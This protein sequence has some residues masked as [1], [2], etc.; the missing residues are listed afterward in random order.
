MRIG[1]IGAGKVGFSL[2]R[3]LAEG[4][5]TVTGYYSRNSRSAREA[6]EFTGEH[7]CRPLFQV[8][9]EKGD[10]QEIYRAKSVIL[11][12]GAK[13]RP[14]GLEDEHRRFVCRQLR[15]AHHHSCRLRRGRMVLLAR[16]GPA[17]A[18]YLPSP[19]GGVPLEISICVDAG[20]DVQHIISRRENFP[21]VCR[22][23]S[24]GKLRCR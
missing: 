9:A 24:H 4:G 14:L 1:F 20:C 10:Q 18:E 7:S 23:R 19:F 8:S 5:V 21:F 13:N 17:E 15:S 12:T 22:G 2:G 16:E 3:Y 11:A 6:A